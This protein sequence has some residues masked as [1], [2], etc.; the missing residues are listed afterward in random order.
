MVRYADDFVILC[1]EAEEAEEE[2]PRLAALTASLAPVAPVC[3]E[4]AVICKTSEAKC[5]SGIKTGR[6]SR[7]AASPASKTTPA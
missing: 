4:G 2:A 3:G 7:R 6:A 5:A 1:R